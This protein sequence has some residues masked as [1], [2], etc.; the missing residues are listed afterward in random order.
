MFAACHRG[1]RMAVPGRSLKLPG[2]SGGRLRR[3]QATFTLSNNN[4]G[5]SLDSAS[6][7]SSGG[8]HLR[9]HQIEDTEG[10]SWEEDTLG[11]NFRNTGGGSHRRPDFTFGESEWEGN[12]H[13][14][15]QNGSQG[16]SS[17]RE[18]LRTRD[19][20]A[21]EPLQRFEEQPAQSIGGRGV[22]KFP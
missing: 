4:S 14:M 1:E 8:I 18:G 17:T 16:E 6:Y 7:E 21:R 5:T 9:A 15:F 12:D 22:K 10:N 2:P 19:F 13:P 20:T 11:R 3:L